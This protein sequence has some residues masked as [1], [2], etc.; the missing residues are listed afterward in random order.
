MSGPAPAFWPG[1][2]YARAVG[3]FSKSSCALAGW[4]AERRLSAHWR[5]CSLA[6]LL[7][8]CLPLLVD[9]ISKKHT[10][11]ATTVI[12][13]PVWVLQTTQAT[14]G[15]LARNSASGEL[16]APERPLKRLGLRETV[17]HILRKD[18]IGAFWRGLGPALALVV[19]PIIQVRLYYSILYIGYS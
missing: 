1:G 8:R 6:S 19:N 15:S 13:N 4:K 17:Q 2:M 10:G 18:G 9:P 5:P 11:S 16:D 3:R 12:S 7:V 14:Q